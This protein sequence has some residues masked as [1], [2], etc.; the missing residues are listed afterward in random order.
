MA[1][2]RPPTLFSLLT[3]TVGPGISPDRSTPGFGQRW[4]RGLSPPVWN[5]TKP[6]KCCLF[7]Y[8][9][10]VSGAPEVVAFSDSTA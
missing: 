10:A 1:L 5:F 4:I 6:Q 8:Y 9:F 7:C 3:L 2:H